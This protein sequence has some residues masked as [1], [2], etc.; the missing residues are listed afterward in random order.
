MPAHGSLRI[1][2]RLQEIGRRGGLRVWLFYRPGPGPRL[3]SW[4]RRRVTLLRNPH[5]E[6]RFGADVY[7]GPGF[8]IDAPRGGTFVCGEGCEFRRRFQ[9]ELAGPDATIEI[10]DR[11]VFTH[12]VLIQ[13][14]SHVSVGSDCQIDQATLLVDGDRRMRERPGDEQSP[15]QRRPLTIGD[16]AMI[17]TKC[18]VIADVGAHSMVGANSVVLQALPAHCLAAGSPAQVIGYFGPEGG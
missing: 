15:A 10:G 8:G 18:T 6:I 14:A 4:L 7:L 12:D 17:T 9:A 5:A 13:C 16:H 1:Q 3:M 11:S 2:E